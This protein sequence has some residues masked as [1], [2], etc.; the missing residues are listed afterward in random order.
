MRIKTGRTLGTRAHTLQ[1]A[2]FG[3]RLPGDP[4]TSRRENRLSGP[5]AIDGDRREGRLICR[6][7]L[8][9]TINNLQNV[10]NV[11]FSTFVQIVGDRSRTFLDRPGPSREVI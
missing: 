11:N 4:Q 7:G 2:I 5:S 6:F 1:N 9:R 3:K 10:K 8:K